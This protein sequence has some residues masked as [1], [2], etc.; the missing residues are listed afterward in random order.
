MQANKTAKSS[1]HTPGPWEFRAYSGVTT[2]VSRH[3]APGSTVRDRLK[4]VTVQVEV[5]VNDD[6]S[7]AAE[8]S[9]DALLIIAAPTLLAALQKVVLLAEE[10]FEHW[11]ADRHS[12]VGKDLLALA[13][14]LQ[15]RDKRID[16]IHAAIASAT[17]AQ[18]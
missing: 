10:M 9:A 15:G 8:A 7:N 12:R 3:E 5:L 11:D 6:Q 16:A 17:G 13:G 14:Q 4:G 1:A 18:P 2:V